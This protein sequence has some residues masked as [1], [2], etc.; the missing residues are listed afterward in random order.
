MITTSDLLRQVRTQIQEKN[1]ETV[2]D[3]A[4]LDV[5]NRGKD[6][7]F[8]L[9]AR[10]YADPIVYPGP[11]VYADSEGYIDI[12]EGA[13]EQRLRSVENR[14]NGKYYRLKRVSNNSVAGYENLSNGDA[15]YFSVIGNR[16]KIY[17]QPETTAEFR[18]WHLVDQEDLVED[19]GQI[20]TI[21]YS[22]WPTPSVDRSVE[23][24]R[25]HV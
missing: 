24:G 21:S 14:R 18:L 16:V 25:A 10:H 17:P 19:Q 12:P 20:S 4:I 7:A 22:A 5:L 13:F 23:I 15:G 11:I 3:Q 8:D 9:L 6:Y 1:E 2:S